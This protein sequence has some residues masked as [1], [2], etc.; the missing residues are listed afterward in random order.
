IA[1]DIYGHNKPEV[2]AANDSAN[3]V[4]LPLGNGDGTFQSPVTFP[5][6]ARAVPV[7][8][9][10]F[11]GDGRLDLAVGNYDAGTVSILLQ[12]ADDS[13]AI[14]ALGPVGAWVG[15]KNSDDQGTQFDVRAE[16]Y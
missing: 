7:L 16:V 12:Q 2:V 15:L 3:D 10:D 4:A 13:A 11:S 5:T 9:G 14:T 1:A 8:A 6:G